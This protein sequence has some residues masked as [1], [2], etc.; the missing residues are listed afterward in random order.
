MGKAVGVPNNPVGHAA[1]CPTYG[2]PLLSAAEIATLAAQ[3]AHLARAASRREVHDHHAGDWPSAWLGRGLDFE[4]ARPYVP[5]D[6][7]RDMDWRT[8]ARLGHPFVKIYREERQPVLH[9]ALDRGPSMR[10]GTRRRL[11]VAQA[12]RVA[13]LAAFAAAER[14]IAVGATLWDSTT[15]RTTP[16]TKPRRDRS[17][18]PSHGRAGILEL[19]GAF[20]APCPP[21]PTEAGE[22]L[23]DGDRLHRLA[24]EL[25]RGTRLLLVSDFAWLDASHAATLAH[26]AERADLLAIRI[27]DPAEIELPDVGLARFQSIDDGNV[28]WLDTGSAAARA[29]HAAAFAAR[30]ANTD[31][32]FT[33]AGVR[34]LDLGSEIDDL[35]PVLHGH[36]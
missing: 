12:A 7:L 14:N 1:L 22:A 8:T 11:K 13:A 6:D 28:R 36:A 31:A 27:S 4:E 10:F 19:I 35:I 26:L 30:R 9:L 32:L 23:H 2:A 20:A 24:A 29:S 25:P 16:R 34:C 5:G 33:R 17:L 15:P 18:P 21:L 3:A